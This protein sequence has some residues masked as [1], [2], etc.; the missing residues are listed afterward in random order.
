AVFAS[1]QKTALL[2]FQENSGN[3]GTTVFGPLLDNLSAATKKQ[4]EDG[5]DFFIEEFEKEFSGFAASAGREYN[6]VDFLEDATA[7]PDQFKAKIKELVNQDYTIDIITIGHGSNKRL[8][9]FQGASITDQTLRDLRNE[10]GRAL[11]IRMVYM[12]NCRGST[13]NSAW[14][15]AGAQVSGGSLGDNWMPEPMLHNFWKNW[16]GGMNFAD[17]ISDAYKSTRGIWSF[18]YKDLTLIPAGVNATQAL[19]DSEPVFQGNGSLDIVT[20]I[21]LVANEILV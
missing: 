12:M 1:T 6:R 18:I 4:I 16:V 9:G 11:P 3:L 10:V 17:A 5:V 15:N 14:I 20:N 2:V 21:K 13:L 19:N 8:V 7:V